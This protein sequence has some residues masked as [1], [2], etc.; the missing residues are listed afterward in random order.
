MKR[1]RTATAILALPG[2]LGLFLP[3]V[4]D[5]SPLKVA[6]N[7]SD[8]PYTNVVWS[9]VPVFLAVIIA[10]WM[11]RRLLSHRISAVEVILAY[12]LSSLS[13]LS[14]LALMLGGDAKNIDTRG[15]LALGAAGV[16]ALLNVLFLVRNVRERLNVEDAAEAFLLAGYLPNAVFLLIV[17]SVRSESDFLGQQPQA[18]FFAVALACAA[19]VTSI[20]LLVR[21]SS[22]SAE[23]LSQK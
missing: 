19:Y 6:L 13:M 7:A 15:I 22:K 14:I 23:A 1:V 18:G 17:F 4:F 9:A 11:L 16:L 3:F 10:V 2:L 8:P 21:R 12:L 20:V 5:T